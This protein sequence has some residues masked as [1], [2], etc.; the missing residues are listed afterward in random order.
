LGIHTSLV[1]LRM[2]LALKDSKSTPLQLVLP[3]SF[4]YF[5]SPGFR[6]AW[7]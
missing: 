1:E 4:G 5:A 6:L 7:T 3:S 2:L